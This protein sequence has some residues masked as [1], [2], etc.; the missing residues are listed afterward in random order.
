MPFIISMPPDNR[1]F[2]EISA[3]FS[4]FSIHALDHVFFFYVD[5]LIDVDFGAII[6][7]GFVGLFEYLI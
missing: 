4:N 1:Y 2:D 6:W 5:L 3:T 7:V